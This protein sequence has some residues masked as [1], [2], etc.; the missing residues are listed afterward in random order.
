[1]PNALV[2]GLW[3]LLVSTCVGC[4]VPVGSGRNSVDTFENH[5]CCSDGARKPV[6]AARAQRR[7]TAELRAR[8]DLADQ[9][10]GRSRCS[11]RSGRRHRARRPWSARSR[12]RR[13]RRC[14][15]AC[16]RPRCSAGSPGTP[17]RRAASAAAACRTSR[18]RGCTTPRRRRG[19]DSSRR[20]ARCRARATS[21]L[22]PL[23]SSL[24]SEIEVRDG[25]R[26]RQRAGVERRRARRAERRVDRV[27]DVELERARRRASGS[28]RR[29][30]VPLRRMPTVI[31]VS[32]IV[33][34]ISG[35]KPSR[36]E[37]RHVLRRLLREAIEAGRGAAAMRRRRRS[38]RT[39]R[40][41]R[42]AA[43]GCTRRCR[44][45]PRPRRS[46]SSKS[47]RVRPR[48]ASI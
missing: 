34:W 41:R 25:L 26:R 3:L 14:C 27:L 2:T 46:S 21:D 44:R 36:I 16:D 31:A 22:T 40:R 38:C 30:T 6:L 28:R 45:S 19:S 5:S 20:G 10:A 4:S 11:S 7:A 47:S 1:M 15:R 18:C 24:C 42:T 43:R 48:R 12:S 8:C 32:S 17:A 33:G 29:S 39:P 37:L 23:V 9:R 35:R 13:R